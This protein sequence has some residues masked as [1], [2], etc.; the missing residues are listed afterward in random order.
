MVDTLFGYP[1]ETVLTTVFVIFSIAKAIVILT[2]TPKDNLWIQR[3]Y[4][5]VEV[6]AL[7]I[8]KTKQGEYTTM[9]EKE[10]ICPNC[11]TVIKGKNG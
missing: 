8:G 10:I 2:P 7:V 3:C 4:R 11:K 1:T 9:L 5:V 6:L